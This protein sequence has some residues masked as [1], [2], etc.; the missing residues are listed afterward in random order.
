[1]QNIIITLNDPKYALIIGP[2]I[3]PN[4]TPGKLQIQKSI[5]T[6]FNMKKWMNAL[7]VLSQPI[8][9]IAV[10]VARFNSALW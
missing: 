10:I 7:I 9:A 5:G 1:M 6:S 4:S 3:L 8:I 2:I